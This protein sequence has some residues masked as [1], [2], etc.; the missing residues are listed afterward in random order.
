MMP[1][2]PKRGRFPPSRPARIPV[3]SPAPPDWATGLAGGKGTSDLM[4]QSILF[5]SVRL[6][7]SG[8]GNPVREPV[9]GHERAHARDAT[10]SV[11]DR[12]RQSRYAPVF[13]G[14]PMTHTLLLI[15]TAVGAPGADD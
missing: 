8:V 2:G 13:R 3:D 14:N 6:R 4:R 9:R 10:C 11:P 12:G 15:A 7:G 5:R 1:G